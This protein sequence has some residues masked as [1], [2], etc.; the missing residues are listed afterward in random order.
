M[1]FELRS[2]MNIGYIVIFV[3]EIRFELFMFIGGIFCFLLVFIED[4]FIY[5]M[6]KIRV[7]FRL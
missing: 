4:G 3:M 5:C 2:G 1:E 6:G 7:F